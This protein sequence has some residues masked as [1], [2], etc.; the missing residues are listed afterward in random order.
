MGLHPLCSIM[1]VRIHM[2]YTFF[3]KSNNIN[4]FFEHLAGIWEI[5]SM[6]Y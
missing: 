6:L 5:Y 3:L 4:F 2:I 1:H